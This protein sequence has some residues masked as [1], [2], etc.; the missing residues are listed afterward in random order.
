MV[1]ITVVLDDERIDEECSSFV[2]HCQTDCKF[3]YEEGCYHTS[4]KLDKDDNCLSY[5]SEEQ[6]FQM[7]LKILNLP[8]APVEYIHSSLFGYVGYSVYSPKEAN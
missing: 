7:L 8:Q 1:K 6:T 5:I 3:Y 4:I 2:V